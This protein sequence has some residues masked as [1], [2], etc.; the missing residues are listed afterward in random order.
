MA[1]NAATLKDARDQALRK[2]QE[3]FDEFWRWR[4]RMLANIDLDGTRQWYQVGGKPTHVACEV[5]GH[6]R[7][8]FWIYVNTSVSDDVSDDPDD[9]RGLQIRPARPAGA[10]QKARPG[11]SSQA[12]T[13]LINEI[14][15]ARLTTNY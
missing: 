6:Q 9:D 8:R 2:Y 15:N 10:T 11:Y 3:H 5:I 7:F 12:E 4:T 14:E 13:L 1:R